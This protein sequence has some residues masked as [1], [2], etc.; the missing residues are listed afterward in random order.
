MAKTRAEIQKAYHERQKATKGGEY[1][2]KEAKRVQKYYRPADQLP[3][4]KL[5]KRR[6]KIQ[7]AMI[8]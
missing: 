2:K 5:R 6:S 8:K 1:M 3:K 4:H 7:K